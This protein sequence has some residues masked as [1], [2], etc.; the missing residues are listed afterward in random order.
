M[1]LLRKI[2]QLL[3]SEKNLNESRIS[4]TAK[5]TLI[6]L[7]KNPN[8]GTVNVDGMKVMT[9]PSGNGIIFT[10]PA[11]DFEISMALTDIADTLGYSFDTKTSK[12]HMTFE[13]RPK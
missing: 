3:V 10:L 1:S 4:A 7:V 2:D 11:D 13:V 12:Q 6:G 9:K 5:R 8:K